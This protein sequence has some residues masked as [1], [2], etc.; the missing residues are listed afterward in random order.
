MRAGVAL[1]CGARLTK[2]PA[3][4]SEHCALTRLAH[5]DWTDVQHW[6]P[7]VN[8]VSG[9]TGPWSWPVEQRLAQVVE[10]AS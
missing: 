6:R 1:T 2:R 4:R 9:T 8:T 3:V 7:V 10:T 5:L